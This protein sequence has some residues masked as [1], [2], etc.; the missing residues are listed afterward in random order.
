MRPVSLVAAPENS[1]LLACQRENRSRSDC[2][3]LEKEG[4]SEVRLSYKQK[5]HAP[6][7][8]YFKHVDMKYTTR[9]FLLALESWQ[10]GQVRTFYILSSRASTSYRNY[11]F[12]HKVA[13]RVSGL[14]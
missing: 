12:L 14:A 13:R 9:T 5:R 2:E 8:A 7:Q 10:V 4:A 6:P 1:A 11:D 3:C